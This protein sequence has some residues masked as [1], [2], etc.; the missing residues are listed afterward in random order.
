MLLTAFTLAATRWRGGSDRSLLVSLETHGRAEDLLDHADLSRTVGWFTGIHPVRL[1]VTGIDADDAL[2]GGPAAGAALKRVKEQL[3]AVPDGGV[4]FGWLRHVHPEAGEELARLG[5][6]DVSFNYLGRFDTGTTGTA[7]WSVAQEGA[8][9]LARAEP[10]MPLAF[11]VELSAVVRDGADGPELV[12]TWTW[13]T[14]L[15]SE[16]EVRALALAWFDQLRAVVDHA[17]RPGSGG[18]TPSD[19]SLSMLDQSDIDQLESELESFT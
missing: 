2:A 1:D 19:V 7:G 14:R 9:L 18:L 6:P 11:P 10:E 4:S 3:R 15:L 13:A 16:D 17:A 5:G 8:G 12:A